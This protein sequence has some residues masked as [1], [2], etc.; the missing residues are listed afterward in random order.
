M[1]GQLGPRPWGRKN[2]DINSV[3]SV[4]NE[5]WQWITKAF[6]GRYF[7]AEEIMK[8]TGIANRKRLQRITNAVIQNKEVVTGR[9]RR[10]DFQ[11]GDLKAIRAFAGPA[12]YNVPREKVIEFAENLAHQRAMAENRSPILAKMLSRR[13]IGR[14]IAQSKLKSGYAETTTDA[15][16]KACA[17]IRSAVSNA[18]MHA[19]VVPLCHRDL[20]LNSDATQFLVG[21]KNGKV[22]VLYIAKSDGQPLKLQPGATEDYSLAFFIK[23]YLLMS[24]GGYTA[25]PIYIIAN[26][27]MSEKEIDV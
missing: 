23:Y 18:A 9:G 16:A 21:N 5:W 19:A 20:I 10:P 17:S 15:R 1:E 22:V 27:F 25:R 3:E 7:T 24:V 14:M 6:K 26:D 11:L 8:M 2:I 12:H 13:S 4:P